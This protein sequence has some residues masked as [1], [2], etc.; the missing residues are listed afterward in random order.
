MINPKEQ[1]IDKD[2]VEKL[3]KLGFERITNISE[4]HEKLSCG[5]RS[6]KTGIHLFPK[7]EASGDTA[8]YFDYASGCLKIESLQHLKD[9]IK[10]FK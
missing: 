4:P 1:Y 10:P 7:F 3:K 6:G 5:Y 8:L 2:S 9:L